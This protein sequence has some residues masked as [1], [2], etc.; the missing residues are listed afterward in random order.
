[1]MSRAPG[2][3]ES[4]APAARGGP[5][6]QTKHQAHHQA[7]TCDKWRHQDKTAPDQQ[8]PASC[9]RLCCH[10]AHPRWDSQTNHSQL[11][12]VPLA[13]SSSA[14][15]AAHWLPG[16]LIR[17]AI[18]W[19]GSNS[20]TDQSR[21]CR[22]LHHPMAGA[23]VHCCSPALAAMPRLLAAPLT[24]AGT[25]C[26]LVMRRGGQGPSMPTSDAQVSAQQQ[27]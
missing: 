23:T 14:I 12:P 21:Q 9:A 2:A 25:C 7:A 24:P 27:A 11:V 13:S 18:Q 5:A 17:L 22:G 3:Q 16:Q 6:G 10:H 20:L 15:S 19:A 1:M 26:Q 8:E 4:G